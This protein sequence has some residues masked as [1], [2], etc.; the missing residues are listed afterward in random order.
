MPNFR[1]NYLQ[2]ANGPLNR[3]DG[4]IR[5]AG[6]VFY[7]WWVVFA[8]IGIQFAGGLF[9]AHSFALYVEE[10]KVEFGWSATVLSV[11]FALTRMESGILGPL[12]GWLADRFG[13]R[14]V[15]VCGTLLFGG[16]LML[17]SFTWS[18]PSYYASVLLIALGASLGGF[19]TL[20]VALVN[21][22]NQHRSKAIAA[23]QL[24]YAA[25][26]LSLPIMAVAIQTFG[27]R[28]TAFA[29]GFIVIAVCLP[30]SLLVKHRPEDIGEQVDG[31]KPPEDKFTGSTTSNSQSPEFTAEQ[32]VKTA[33]FWLLSFGHAFALLTVSAVML[34]AIAHLKN[35]LSYSVVEAASVMSLVMGCQIIGQALG[36]YLGDR[37]DKRYICIACMAGHASALLLLAYASN[38][39]MVI[40]FA[41]IHGISWGARGPLMV[42]LRADYFGTRAF[43]MIMGIS[44][45][46]VM[47]GMMGGPIVGGVLFDYYGD[48]VNAFAILGLVSLL[49]AFCFY[50]AKP[51]SVPEN[52]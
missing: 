33:A 38:S 28:P 44:S 50:F 43:G 36:G 47:F 22:F 51:P 10:L 49:G 2:W 23:S 13:P 20:M 6:H 48:Y 35:G 7:G 45:L 9:F 46:V 3:V 32:A 12:Q 8:S 39:V 25:G 15:L 4:V 37:Y 1:T 14:I 52:H 41:V 26:G 17:F 16:G 27:W 34:H 11:A 40:A 21:W 5:P 31:A 24:G 18:I 19:A 42:A 29:S 30:L